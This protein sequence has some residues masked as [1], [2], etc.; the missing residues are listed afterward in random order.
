M[1]ISWFTSD[2]RL[3]AEWL[4]RL[5]A[6]R[7]EL[8]IAEI[9]GWNDDLMARHLGSFVRIGGP[10]DGF[11]EPIE[12]GVTAP[13]GPILG[14]DGELIYFGKAFSHEDGMERSWRG[15]KAPRCV[16]LRPMDENGPILCIVSR[17]GG[18][19]WQAVGQVTELSGFYNDN[20][21]EPHVVQLPGGRLVG[22]I[23]TQWAGE[24]KFHLPFSLA[25]TVSDDGGVTWSKL[26]PLDVS[27][28]P[29]HLMLHSSGVLICT[30][31]YRASA[32]STQ[33]VGSGQRVILSKDGGN[34]WSDPIILRDDGPDSDLGYPATCE[35]DD[36]TLFTVYYQKQR[37]GENCSILSTTWKLH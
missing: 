17:D 20:L 27:G 25:Q 22:M 29:P 10:G 35:A 7:G 18:H 5:A 6:P 21:H 14:K 24:H 19:N 11:G 30:Y 1:L 34:T 4:T 33:D 15:E 9:Q 16:K 32:D 31:G 13:H 2:T 23:R 8:S 37:A 28:S 12:V 36:G 3:Y 26:K